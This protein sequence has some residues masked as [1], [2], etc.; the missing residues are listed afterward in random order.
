MLNFVILSGDNIDV[1]STLSHRI[2]GYPELE[3]GTHKD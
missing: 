3:V 1:Q 2:M